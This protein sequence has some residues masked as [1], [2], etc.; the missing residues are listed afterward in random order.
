[1]QCTDNPG[2]IP[3]FPTSSALVL[4]GNILS[5]IGGVCGR[6]MQSYPSSALA[7][8]VGRSEDQKDRPPSVLSAPYHVT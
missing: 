1:M 7:T 5:G 4:C 2:G 8:L 3:T 6:G